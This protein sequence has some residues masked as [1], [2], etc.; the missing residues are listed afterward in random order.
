M[1]IHEL[2]YP[3]LNEGILDGIKSVAAKATGAVS[4]A[5]GAVGN[6][7][8]AAGNALASTTSWDST[9][10]N[11]AAKTTAAQT[12]EYVDRLAQQ[13]QV[14]S[15]S[16]PRNFEPT[17]PAKAAKAAKASELAQLRKE[18]EREKMKDRL[19]KSIDQYDT[20]TGKI[21]QALLK[22]GDMPLPATGTLAARPNPYMTPAANT[23]LDTTKISVPPKAG[24]PTQ[25]ELDKLQQRIKAATGQSVNEAFAD[26]PGAKPVAGN[27]VSAKVTAMPRNIKGQ[28]GVWSP[29][30]AKFFQNWVDT[31]FASV[32][33]GT[34]Q[35]VTMDMVRDMP[36]FGSQL[37][38]QA[39]AD[40]VKS[41]KDPQQN[42][43]AVKKYLTLAVQG[44][45]AKSAQLKKENPDLT[46]KTGL[47]QTV[48][49]TGNPEADQLLIKQGYKVAAI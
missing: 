43:T 16:I 35:K 12:T 15:K 32:I 44:M 37:K 23:P 4:N 30:Y 27:P 38:N 20:S 10:A 9:I 41:R 39:L 40:V 49:S 28:S 33:P 13:W 45:Q 24:A 2:T 8:K 47:G 19:R 42:D 48:K 6:A 1:Q 17:D 29:T 22:K 3:Q 7:A 26:L 25:A 34:T 31:K 14:A 46:K 21:A 18:V 11:K 5:A 36:E